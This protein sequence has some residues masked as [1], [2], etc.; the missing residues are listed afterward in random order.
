MAEVRLIRRNRYQIGCY[1]VHKYN[2]Y[3]RVAMDDL[4]R[5]GCFIPAHEVI[6]QSESLDE[7]LG[8]CKAH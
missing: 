7:A 8:W 5:R 6:F 3:W 2:R 1:V 4:K